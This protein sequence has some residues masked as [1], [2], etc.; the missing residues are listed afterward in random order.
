MTF[1][2]RQKKRLYSQYLSDIEQDRNG[3]PVPGEIAEL[4]TKP[5]EPDQ[6]WQLMVTVRGTKRMV[7]LGPMM[8][9]DAVG[10]SVEAINRQIAQGQR[11][12][13]TKAAAYPMTPISQGA[14]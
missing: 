4:M 1:T 8:C 14:H 13:W 3:R 6:L 10:I 5:K 7:P 2:R 12:D 9:K 11:R